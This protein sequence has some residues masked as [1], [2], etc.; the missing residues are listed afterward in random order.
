MTGY[1]EQNTGIYAKDMENDTN[2]KTSALEKK[3]KKN[4]EII[5]KPGK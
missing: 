4:F 1:K 5:V 3:E 2:N